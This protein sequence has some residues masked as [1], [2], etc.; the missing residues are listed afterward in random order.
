MRTGILF[1]AP[2]VILLAFGPP[3]YG[4]D[5]ESR[6]NA[7]EERLAKQ[8]KTIQDQQGQLDRLKEELDAA[9]Q[10]G[11]ARAGKAAEAA[12]PATPE[13]LSASPWKA[14]EEEASAVPGPSRLSGLFGGSA[15]TNPYISLV[16]DTNLYTSS[17]EQGELEGRGIPG[18]TSSGIGRRKGFNL[19]AAE[20]FIFAP[21]DPYFNLYATIPV[22]E[23][24]AEVEEAYFVTTSLPSGLQVKGGKFK[25][26]FGRIN[27]QHPHAWDFA[28]VPLIYRAFLGDEG[29]T[30]KGGQL[31][32]LPPLPFYT[33]LG[34]EVLQGENDV[35]FGSGAK[36][37]PH[38]FA[39]F[40]K[41]SFDTGDFSTVLFGPSVLF[42][43]SRNG[44][45]VE[46][47]TFTG[48]SRLYCFESTYKWQPSKTR[49]LI[50]QGEYFYG[51]QKGNLTDDTFLTSSPLDRTQDGFYLQ[52]LYQ[53]G[54]WRAGARY[55]R[56]DL[57]AHDFTS[58]GVSEGFG[59]RPWRVTGAIEFNPSEFSRIRIQYNHDLSGRDGRA[60]DE[61]FLQFVMGIGAHAAHA[62]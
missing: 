41:A 16:L 5:F 32:Y 44:S 3:A 51:H 24:G 9:I 57:F 56:L 19:E 4:D 18:Y 10:P 1:L 46:G 48:N 13:D 38:A 30:E 29:I 54:R 8:Q 12:I 20:L 34:V 52:A 59:P 62:F 37:G 53:M 26:G 50:A 15:L 47:G 33:L 45:L 55:D 42:G 39:G 2:L 58:G 43:S 6:L 22:T 36:S 40:A 28:D 31:S 21:V 61:W 7:L 27:G 25:S 17:M 11:P 60:N 14:E 35:L 49:S 23:D